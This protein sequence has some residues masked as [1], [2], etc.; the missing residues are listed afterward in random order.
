M[1]GEQVIGWAILELMG[2]RRLAGYV[3]EATLAGGS[4]LAI[5]ICLPDDGDRSDG[6]DTFVDPDDHDC[7]LKRIATQFYSPQSVYAITPTSRD[8]CLQVAQRNQPA[9][10]ARW[11]LPAAIEHGGDHGFDDEFAARGFE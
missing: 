10:V 1:S 9:P 3:S 7:P 11:E 5:D 6:Q 2:H 8:T 4:F